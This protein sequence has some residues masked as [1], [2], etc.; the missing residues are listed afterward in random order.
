MLLI[1]DWDG[2]LCDSTGRIVA[3]MQSAADELGFDILEDQTIKDIIGLGLPEAI[4]MLYPDLDDEQRAQL[5]QG[6]SEHYLERDKTPSS[7][8]PQVEE[9]LNILK[10]QGHQL[11]VATGK[12]RRGLNRVM[13]GMDVHHLFE[14]TR[15]ADETASKPHPKMVLE[16]LDM[17]GM[18]TEEAIVIGDT[19]FDMEMALN[20]N[21][22]RIG[23]SYGAHPVHRLHKWE[24]IAC[25]DD[26]EELLKHL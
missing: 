12:S 23:V 2:T 3:A 13:D 25:L 20:A 10:S 24:P 4:L 22:P 18:P 19:E 5:R 15:C 17:F 7:F 26:F 6:Y 1:F 8:F 16:L 9:T 11:T 21:V 14:A